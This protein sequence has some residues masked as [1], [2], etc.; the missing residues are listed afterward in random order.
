MSPRNRK[1]LPDRSRSAELH[2]LFLVLALLIFALC[3]FGVYSAI[4]RTA[5]RFSADYYFPFLKAARGAENLLADQ[6]LLL[7]SK[8]T[9]ARALRKLRRDNAVL[10][11]DHAVVADLKQENSRLRALLKLKRK[12][13]FHPV[14]AE[15]LT[16]DPLNWQEQF[17]ID[18]GGRAGI[19]PGNPVVT[20]VRGGAGDSPIALIGRVKSVTG[21]TALVSTILSQDFKISVSLPD[22]K[23]A[24]ILEGADRVAARHA[25]L[26][27]LPPAASP[28]PGQT[29]CTNAFSGN[30][31]PGLPAGRIVA[32]RG[33]PRGSSPRPLCLEAAVKPFESPA[34]VR[35]VAVF[36]KDIP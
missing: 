11:A 25:T 18:K 28:A 31:P 24:G 10:A 23:S 9:L 14:F 36:V 5:R 26:K 7:Q 33:M 6:A 15:V 4:R 3:V 21:H 12:G 17:T 32:V 30:S 2:R 16:R 1:S 35:F 8:T 29:V 13:T 27:L 20:M 34:E 22:R 19:T